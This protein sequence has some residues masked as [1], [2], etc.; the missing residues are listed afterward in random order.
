[1]RD[2]AIKRPRGTDADVEVQLVPREVAVVIPGVADADNLTC[3]YV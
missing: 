2:V 3:A 1:M